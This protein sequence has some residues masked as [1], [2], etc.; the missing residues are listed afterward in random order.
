MTIHPFI[1]EV[2]DSFLQFALYFQNNSEGVPLNV[3]MGVD[4]ISENVVATVYAEIVEFC[5]TVREKTKTSF[6]ASQLGVDLYFSR[7]TNITGFWNKPEIY[8]E[9]T[10]LLQ[11][12]AEKYQPFTILNV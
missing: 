10:D 12:L 5:T 4:D 1:E 3:Y 2:V 11:S 9:Y 8:G 6:N 7:N